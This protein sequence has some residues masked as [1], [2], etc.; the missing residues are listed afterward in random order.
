MLHL[1]EN[2]LIS[3]V[4]GIRRRI[5]GLAAMGS[6]HTVWRRRRGC[7]LWRSG[8][9][10]GERLVVFLSDGA[11]EE[12]RGSDLAP[13]WWRVDSCGLVMP[14]TINNGRR[15]D[16]RTTM[17]QEGGVEW[18]IDYLKLNGFDPI[19]FDGRDPAAFV[20]AILEMES[21]LEVAGK[22]VRSCD[23]CYPVL[24][25]YGIAVAPKGAGF[26][27]AG[28]NLAHNL[29]L[30]SNPHTDK[31]AGFT[32]TGGIEWQVVSGGHRHLALSS[33]G[34]VARSRSRSDPPKKKHR[35][36]NLVP[37]RRQ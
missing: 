23:E 30:G 9:L 15:I 2:E 36:E 33:C 19:V 35:H 8:W 22:S 6:S 31:V 12:Q 3:F 27:G 20:W 28:T 4:R 10:P 16:Q 34:S 5:A 7:S 32:R 37:C 13:R 18:F 14:I 17:S 24:L 1:C 21:R 29:P 25:P 26:Y 11:L